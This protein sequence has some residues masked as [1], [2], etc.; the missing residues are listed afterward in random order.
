MTCIL[1]ISSGKINKSEKI[2]KKKFSTALLRRSSVTINYN[3][4]ILLKLFLLVKPFFSSFWCMLWLLF[5]LQF[6]PKPEG[7]GSDLTGRLF[8]CFLGFFYF[9]FLW[10]PPTNCL[11]LKEMFPQSMRNEAWYCFSDELCC[12]CAKLI[13]RSCG[14]KKKKTVFSQIWV[15]FRMEVWKKKEAL[16]CHTTLLVKAEICGGCRELW[17]CVEGS[18]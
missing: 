14:K 1:Y 11:H 17:S 12:F 8:Y 16:F 6:Y 15:D 7:F 3:L 5:H 2:W 9:L 13:F 4:G 10:R 18:L